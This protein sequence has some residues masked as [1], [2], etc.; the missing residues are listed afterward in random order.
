MTSYFLARVFLAASLV[1][2]VPAAYAQQQQ[3]QQQQQ[4]S[5]PCHWWQFGRCD[6]AQQ[7]QIDGL[8]DDAPRAGTVITV[9]VSTNTV[10]LFQDGQLVRKAPAA[11]GSGKV[12]ENGDDV[13]QFETPRGHLKVRGKIKDPVWRK[14]D[15]AFIEAGERVPPPDSPKRLVKGHLGKYALT[16]GDGIMIHGT[17]DEDSIGRYVSHGCIRVPADMLATLW[18]TAKV[19]TD[20]YV[21][22]SKPMQTA[23]SNNSH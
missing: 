17:D 16:L 5:K 11:T 22:E 1:V 2:A 3:A 15:W 18:K 4:Q 7:Q 14:P 10:F 23:N 8:P 13:W 6:N 21:F 12:L 9:D 19:G 20:V